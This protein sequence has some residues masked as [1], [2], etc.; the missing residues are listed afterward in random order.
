MIDNS[1]WQ[2]INLYVIGIRS[3]VVIS[4]D[5]VDVDLGQK[6]SECNGPGVPTNFCMQLCL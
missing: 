6:M 1:K 4:I 5:I 2:V 3:D